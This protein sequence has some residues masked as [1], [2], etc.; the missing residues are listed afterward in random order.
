MKTVYSIYVNRLQCTLHSLHVT[1]HSEQF[2]LQVY[3]ENLCLVPSWPHDA[4]QG[5]QDP[6]THI[7]AQLDMVQFC[8]VQGST[9]Q[10]IT[11]QHSSVQYRALQYRVQLDMLQYR[12]L[13]YVKKLYCTAQ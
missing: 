11:V 8:T 1:L 13:H 5:S 6:G 10:Y 4:V 7:L 2:T 12:S 9:L 3:S